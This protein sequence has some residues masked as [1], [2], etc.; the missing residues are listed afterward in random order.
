M[1]PIVLKGFDDAWLLSG[2]AVAE[3]P[4]LIAARFEDITLNAASQR[5]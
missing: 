2:S 4:A 3:P 5:L 1:L